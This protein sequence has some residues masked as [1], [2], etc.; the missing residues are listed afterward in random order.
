[1]SIRVTLC[2]LVVMGLSVMAW[3]GK[4]FWG[5]C[6]LVFLMAFLER[7]DMPRTIMGIPGLNLWNIL[8]LNV[9]CA[10]LVWRRR[11]VSEWTVSAPLKRA[12]LLY[13][14]VVIWAFARAFISPTRF[15]EEGRGAMIMDYV[16]N[17]VK[18]LIPSLLLYFGA[19]SRQRVIVALGV[20]VF[21]YFVLGV[22]VIKYMGLSDFSGDRLQA[23]AARVLVRDV[24]YHRVDLSMML[25]GAS[26]SLL[27]VSS[28]NRSFLLWSGCWLGAGVVMLGQA[29]TGGR[30]GYVAWG[31]I[32]VVLCTL[33]WRKL[34]LVLPLFAI[35]AL[36]V[37]GVR[38]R[39]LQGFASKDS[40]GIVSA[41]D[42]SE[43]TSGRVI[44]WPLVLDRIK[45][46][47]VLGHG[48]IAMI[49]TGT[50]SVLADEGEIFSHPHNAYLEMLLDNGVIGLVLVVPIYWIVARRSVSLFVDRSSPLFEGAGGV[51]VALLFAL[52]FAGIG[53]QTFY[54]REGMVGM[55]A[56]IGVAMRV[57]DERELARA[58]GESTLFGIDGEKGSPRLESCDE[59]NLTEPCT[60]A[61]ISL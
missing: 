24:G 7:R 23:R 30:A 11:E 18:F 36:A 38:E 29:L 61:R 12:F 8:C 17:P 6:G 28:L 60:A 52:L 34:L 2:V 44:A 53:A 58:G 40:V 10:W 39:A 15:Y 42:S 9:V 19:N 59:S 21:M 55:W 45:E 14:L 49:R 27:A 57:W 46:A 33:R 32:A 35:A 31:A 54:P 48:R 22:F 4:W 47:P 37:P 5:A 51:A 43:I 50:A 56:A 26:W 3:R 20:V 25:A 16:I 13:L 1:M 41:T